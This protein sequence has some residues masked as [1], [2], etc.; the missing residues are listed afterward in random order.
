MPPV[1]HITIERVESATPE[2]RALI[3]AL[4][5]ELD[6][7]FPQEQQHGLSVEQVFQPGVAFFIARIDGAPVGCGGVKGDDGF[8]ELKRMYVRPDMRGRGIVQAV[9]AALEAEARA[10]GYTRLKLETGKVLHAA[11]AVYKRAGFTPCGPFGEYLTM[12]PYPIAGS[13]FLEKT[14]A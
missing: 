2:A 4:E 12:P 6:A 5:R 14:I 8:A 13:V 9:L 10:Q 7:Y 1:P 11:I 3:E